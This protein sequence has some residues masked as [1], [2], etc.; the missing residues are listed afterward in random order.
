MSNTYY[1]YVLSNRRRT[2]LYIGLTNDLSRR[3]FEHKKG[4]YSSFTKKYRATHL[5]YFEVYEDIEEA[6]NREKQLKGWKREKKLQL[7]LK[8]NRFMKDL[9]ID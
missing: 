2:V 1:V 7:I 5:V 3:L 8:S 9:D 6:I 4:R